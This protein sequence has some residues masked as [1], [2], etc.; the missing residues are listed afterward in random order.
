MST[1][2]EGGGNKINMIINEHITM[3]IMH[4]QNFKTKLQG[5]FLK[6]LNDIKESVK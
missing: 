2:G 4:K 1:S 5:F 6:S 3:K